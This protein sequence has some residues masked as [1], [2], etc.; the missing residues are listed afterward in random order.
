MAWARNG[1]PTTLDSTGDD[2]DISDLTAKK[3]NVF[4]EHEIVSGAVSSDVTFNNNGNS[5]YAS[6][7]NNDGGS[8]ATSVSQTNYSFG[9]ANNDIFALMYFCSIS[10]EEKLG[11]TFMISAATGAGTAPQRREEV[12][13]FVPSPDA[14]IVRIDFTNISGGSYDT[15][16]NLSA[17]GT[18]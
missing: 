6:R 1:T 5:V 18:D 7:T 10:D 12:Q 8:D 11:I 4:L 9:I 16:T 15:D 17:L 13:K 3:F 2:L 14:D